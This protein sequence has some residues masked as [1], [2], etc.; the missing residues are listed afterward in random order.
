M[1]ENVLIHAEATGGPMADCEATGRV[2]EEVWRTIE[3]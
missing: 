3:N 1:E 2:V